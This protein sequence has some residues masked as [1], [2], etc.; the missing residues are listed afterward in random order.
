M[1]RV[2]PIPYLDDISTNNLL[3]YEGKLSGVI[4]IDWMG[5][6][7]MLTFAAMTKVALLNMDLD[8]KYVDY[9]LDEFHPNA[10]EYRAF[11]FYCLMYCVDFMGGERH[12]IS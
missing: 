3:I 7:D 8:I 2:R 1:D 9:L 4:D 11:V 6:G 10:I 5:F 12:A